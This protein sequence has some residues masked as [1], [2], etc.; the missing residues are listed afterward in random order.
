MRLARPFLHPLEPPEGEPRL[1]ACL[2]RRHA[3]TLE[4]SRL[5]IDMKAQFGV[6]FCVRRFSAQARARYRISLGISRSI[7]LLHA[8]HERDGRREP[9]PIAGF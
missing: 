5:F 2:V 9:R 1:A 7:A 8:E 6:Q 3:A 4:L